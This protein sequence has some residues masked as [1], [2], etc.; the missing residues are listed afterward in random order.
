MNIWGWVAIGIVVLALIVFVLVALG[1]A[2][3]LGPLQR[4]LADPSVQ[5]DVSA[6]QARAEE[7]NLAIA[8][9]AARAQVAQERAMALKASRQQSEA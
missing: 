1:T 8:H 3:R 4:A 5:Q 7:L 2:R 9:V 6:L